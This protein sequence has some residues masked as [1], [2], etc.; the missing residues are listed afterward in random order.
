[1]W[2]TLPHVYVLLVCK[3]MDKINLSEFV[4]LGQTLP[5]TYNQGSVFITMF[6]ILF[7]RFCQQIQIISQMNIKKLMYLVWFGD[8]ET[9]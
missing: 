8:V 2:R 9:I 1:M 7:S 5:H 3:V 6:W 4:F